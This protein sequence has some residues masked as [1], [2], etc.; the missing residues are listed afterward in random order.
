MRALPVGNIVGYSAAVEE[1]VEPEAELLSR[2]LLEEK[3]SGLDSSQ[4]VNIQALERLKGDLNSVIEDLEGFDSSMELSVG[5]WD[6]LNSAREKHALEEKKDKLEEVAQKEQRKQDRAV[7]RAARK[8]AAAAKD[9]KTSTEAVS[10]SALTAATAAGSRRS[11]RPTP[12]KV[13]GARATAG[14]RTRTQATWGKQR[15][16]ELDDTELYNASLGKPAKRYVATGTDAM[17]DFLRSMPAHAL[18]TKADEAFLAIKIQDFL[19]LQKK[20]VEMQEKFRRNPTTQELAAEF[21]QQEFEFIQRWKD[22]HRARDRMMTCNQRLVIS[23]ARRYQ[24]KG[25]DMTDLIAEGMTGLVR[26]VEKFDH[27]KGFKFSTYAT[28]WIRQAITRSIGEFGRTIRLPCHLNEMLGKIARTEQEFID[29]YR[30]IPKVEELAQ[31]LNM[32]VKKLKVIRIA[33]RHPRALED[34]LK[35]GDPESSTVGDSIED[36]SEAESH[37]RAVQQSMKTDLR[38]VLSTLS[39]REQGILSMRYG[40]EDGKP[41]TLEDIGNSF[42]VTRER[43]R[44]IENK[45]MAKLKDPSRHKTLQ[46]YATGAALET[47]QGDAGWKSGINRDSSQ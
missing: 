14:S 22:G 36:T 27:T 41:K 26:S 34:P 35:S 10:R 31:I 16:G 37:Q 43:I 13:R 45:A 47:I 20:Y 2:D 19:S 11:T 8:V 5:D 6:K 15:A 30:R 46:P 39:K 3:F 33:S 21:E 23:I 24:N 25:L 18:L 12:T 4:I 32:P 42:Q 28:W 9:V 17:A 29:Q 44:Q 7:K 40:L 1:V 38:H